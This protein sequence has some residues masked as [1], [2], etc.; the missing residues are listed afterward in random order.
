MLAPLDGELK[1]LSAPV[2]RLAL[3][4]S[5][6]IRERLLARGDELKRAGF[7]SQVLVEEDFCP[8]FLIDEKGRRQSLKF[9]NRDSKFRTKGG[10]REFSL[11][12]LVERAENAPETL[13]P[14]ALMRSVVQDYLLPTAC[15]FGGAAEIAYF[16]QN[17]VIYD[18]LERPA[19]PVLHRQSFTIVEAKA[20]RT[21]EKYDLKF[22]DILAG[23]E[24]VLPSLVEKYLN[25]ETARIIASA[26]EKIN[27]EL[28]RLDR[29]FQ[30]FDPALAE[31]LATRRRKILY[32]IGA[33]RKK[34]HYAQLEKDEILRRQIESM[35]A[36]LA[37]GGALQERTLNV[38]GFLNSYGTYF[39]DWIYDAIDL[40][41]KGHRIIYF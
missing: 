34:F 16:A 36:S 28:N 18:I 9:D 20:R 39:I 29:N 40:D 30:Q 22:S 31:N 1:R 37:P 4:R 33:L 27:A 7:H 38:T 41:D 6:E 13:S 19:T 32:H 15:Y 35:F 12:G 25:P 23:R 8:F 14:N 3:E 17:S 26:E 24:S 21:M 5:A 11:R 10:G 2:F